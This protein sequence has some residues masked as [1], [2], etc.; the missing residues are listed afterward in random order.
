MV[1]VTRE[2]LLDE[3]EYDDIVADVACELETKYG[4]LASIVIPQP[5]QQGV[6][7]DPPGVGFV[8]VQF[9]DPIHAVCALPVLS[10]GLSV[11]LPAAMLDANVKSPSYRS[12]LFVGAG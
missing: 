11:C 7:K 2:E 12:H 3:E 1:Q 9:V 10:H 4:A 5:S 8:F 6:P